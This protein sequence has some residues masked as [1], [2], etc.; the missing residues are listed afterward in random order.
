[1]NSGSVAATSIDSSTSTAK[2]TYLAERS[3]EIGVGQSSSSHYVAL[4]AVVLCSSSIQEL[5][6]L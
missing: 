3:A 2:S 6:F 1:M 5:F 4:L